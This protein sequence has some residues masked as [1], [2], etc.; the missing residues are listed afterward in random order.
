MLD[1]GCVIHRQIMPFAISVARLE[2]TKIAK[3][4]SLAFV[5]LMKIAT[6]KV[7]ICCDWWQWSSEW[8]WWHRNNDDWISMLVTKLAKTVSNILK[9]S[10]TYVTKI[11][12]TLRF[13]CGLIRLSVYSKLTKSYEN[14]E[15]EYWLE[16]MNF[17]CMKRPE[18]DV[19]TGNGRITG[20]RI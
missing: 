10:P 5:M 11:D 4:R 12:M 15:S 14:I 9:L 2:N 20:L 1:S 16:G 8:C 3:S 7:G 19:N 6:I 17:R 13:D 18:M